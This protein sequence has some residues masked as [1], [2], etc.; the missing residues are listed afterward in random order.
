MERNRL[1]PIGRTV[2]VIAAEHGIETRA[3]LLRHFAE[4][5][6]R[7]DPGSVGRCL[8]GHAPMYRAFA[9]ALRDTLPLTGEQRTRLGADWIESSVVTALR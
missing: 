9:R 5:G 7:L 4:H 6:H 3:E 2:M 8:Y 1:A